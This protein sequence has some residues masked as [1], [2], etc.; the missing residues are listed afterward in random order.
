MGEITIKIPQRTHGHFE[1]EDPVAAEKILLN[2]K[3]NSTRTKKTSRTSR[4]AKFAKLSAYAEKLRKNPDKEM[5][6]VWA[7][8]DKLRNE[9]RG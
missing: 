2:V 4:K 5:L 7:I 8:A 1:I 6:E 3:E 9:W